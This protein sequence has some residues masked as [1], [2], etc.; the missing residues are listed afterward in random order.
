MYTTGQ[1][2]KLG[3]IRRLKDLLCNIDRLNILESL[4]ALELDLVHVLLEIYI[5]L[6]YWSS[7]DMDV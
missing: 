4:W 6:D 3:Q 2:L 7:A 1:T 5:G